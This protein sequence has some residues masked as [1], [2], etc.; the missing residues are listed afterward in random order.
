M[1]LPINREVIHTGATDTVVPLNRH[2]DPNYSLQVDSGT[3]LAEGTLDR[4]NRGETP[5]WD[6]LD[7]SGGTAI[8]AVTDGIIKV[9]SAPIEAIRLT[10]TGAGTI[11]IF[12]SGLAE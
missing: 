8:T 1:S 6:T 5:T 7:D 10:S 12:Q 4:V 11:R 9:L 2:G 3:W